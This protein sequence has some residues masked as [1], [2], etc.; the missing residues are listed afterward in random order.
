MAINVISRIQVRSGFN[1]DLPQLAKGEFGWSTDTQRL[2]IGNGLPGAY[3]TGD[4]APSAGNTEILTTRSLTASVG[5]TSIVFTGLAGGYTVQTGAGGAAV[6]LPIQSIVDEGLISVKRFGAKGDG[7]TDDTAAVNRALFQLFC[8]ATTPQVRRT[9]YFPAGVYNISADCVKIPPYA[10]VVGD[11]MDCTFIRQTDTTQSH[12]VKF[13]D[14]VQQIDASYGGGGATLSQYV[15]VSDIS[16]EHAYG[17]NVMSAIG[18]SYVK[19]SRVKFNSGV[20][21]PSVAVNDYAAVTLVSL[22]NVNSVRWLF[23]NCVFTKTTYGFVA[24]DDSYSVNFTNCSFLELYKAIKLGEPNLTSGAVTGPRAY[25]IAY[26][27]FDKI[28]NYAVQVENGEKILSIGNYYRDVGN[29][30]NGISSPVT[31]NIRFWGTDCVSRDDFFD[32]TAAQAASKAWII[33]RPT[34]TIITVVSGN[35]AS[36]AGF[37]RT[38]ANNTLPSSPAALDIKIP[39]TTAAGFELTYSITRGTLS[40]QGRLRSSGI[41]SND[42]YSENSANSLGI[43]LYVRTLGGYWQVFYSMDNQGLDASMLANYNYFQ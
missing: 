4:G 38:L 28:S 5:S 18:S 34:S 14:G 36:S 41:S 21:Q 26:C 2:Y 40:R 30:N 43:K 20:F 22:A 3:P 16:F 33:Y 39:I 7:V 42:E 23:D 13:C 12:V 27:E 11:G 15:T 31:E 17:K 32:R 19:M 9:L 37:T 6:N 29:N 24:N 25:R 8:R 10:S 35:S 1:E